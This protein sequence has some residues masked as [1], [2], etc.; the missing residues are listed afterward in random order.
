MSPITRSCRAKSRHDAL[1]VELRATSLDFARDERMGESDQELIGSKLPLPPERVAVHHFDAMRREFVAQRVGGDKI[2]GGAGF[3]AAGE[4]GF[5]FGFGDGGGF[6]ANA[7]V[8]SGQVE[9]V[10]AQH[11]IHRVNCPKL[12]VGRDGLRRKD[13]IQCYQC[14]SGVQ[15]VRKRLIDPGDLRGKCRDDLLVTLNLFQGPSLVPS[16]CLRLRDGC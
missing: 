10:Q 7:E 12:G 9:Q 16:L 15:V 4:D 8:G 11:G 6:G 13:E 5:N 3:L 14:D 1:R 2:L